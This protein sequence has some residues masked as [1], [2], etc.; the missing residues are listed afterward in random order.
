[1]AWVDPPPFHEVKRTAETAYLRAQEL[2]PL[3]ERAR[4]AAEEARGPA[5]EAEQ[6]FQE[7]YAR[8]TEVQGQAHSLQ[9]ELRAR[10]GP[11]LGGNE[12]V[13]D[14][15]LRHHAASRLEHFR[16]GLSNVA[17]WQPL[18]HTMQSLTWLNGATMLTQAAAVVSNEVAYLLGCVAV[19]MPLMDDSLW[20]VALHW[21][22]AASS[23]APWANKIPPGW[24]TS[25][26]ISHPRGSTAWETPLSVLAPV[27]DGE[28]A[29]S[30]VV[31]SVL[32]QIPLDDFLK[33]RGGIKFVVRRTDGGAPEWIKPNDHSDFWLDFGPAID[34]FNGLL[35]SGQA[36]RVDEHDG[37]DTTPSEGKVVNNAKPTVMTSQEA[38]EAIDGLEEWSWAVAL[39]QENMDEDKEE[40]TSDDDSFG[41]EIDAKN[42][43]HAEA[44]MAQWVS[45][46]DRWEVLG[47]SPPRQPPSLSRQVQHLRAILLAAQASELPVLPSDEASHSD[48]NR[49]NAGQT[50][51]QQDLHGR[52]KEIERAKLAADLLVRC[53]DVDDSFLQSYD[54]AA[55][56][57]RHAQQ[58]RERL[59]EA[60]TNATDEAAR[61]QTEAFSA[62]EAA[63]RSVGAM[64]GRP[65]EV[66]VNELAALAAHVAGAEET[67]RTLWSG[68]WPFGSG[69]QLVFVGQKV[70][71]VGGLDAHIVIQVYLEGE[72]AA[73]KAAVEAF[74]AAEEREALNDEQASSDDQD[75]VGPWQAA[76][77]V[78]DRP[79]SSSSPPSPLQSGAAGSCTV[80]VVSSQ[81]CAFDTAIIAVA[82]GESFPDSGLHAPVHLHLGAVSHQHAKWMQLPARWESVPP[83]NEA[84]DGPLPWIPMQ[85]YAMTRSDGSPAAVDPVLHAAC[86]RLPFGEAGARHAPRGLEMVLKTA[87]HRWVQQADGK[88]FYIELPVVAVTGGQQ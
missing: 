30:A 75:L 18:P 74:K 21:S 34:I 57:A 22:V 70:C 20:D 28:V 78:A 3:V 84:I 39:S 10:A 7:A 19:T 26:A 54:A 83:S 43:K 13:A 76:A 88:N 65:A 14:A 87:D 51:Q 33:Q 60:H 86:L 29:T 45:A 8:L 38:L 44:P 72:A 47:N 12:V 4:S 6:R 58:E 49:D 69:R 64:R 66:T 35:R 79:T 40:S 46:I 15:M 41:Q 59:W 32:I 82:A 55:L 61:L 9:D 24:H 63:R 77:S 17:F 2:L 68:L 85:T 73:V 81:R 71:R 16:D 42:E 5:A 67:S 56:T 36:E 25:P 80:D 23:H 53:E 50:M 52:E 1:M 11:A 48:L 37:D 31:H 62:T 27:I